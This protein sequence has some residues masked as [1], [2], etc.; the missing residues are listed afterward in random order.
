MSIFVL[1]TL[2]SSTVR[3][4]TTTLAVAMMFIGCSSRENVVSLTPNQPPK[5]TLAI[6]PPTEPGNVEPGETLNI[7]CTVVSKPG[8]FEPAMA[9]FSVSAAKLKL[10]GKTVRN[11]S[12]STST[13]RESKHVDDTYMFSYEVKA[14]DNPS[15]YVIE[16]KVVGVDPSRPREGPPAAP[17]ADGTPNKPGAHAEFDSPSLEINVKAS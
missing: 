15:Q 12:V 13:V 6:Q 17:A 4:G 5:V 14:P 8:G 7:L 16:A 3:I 2:N 1:N 10:G 9:I 11:V